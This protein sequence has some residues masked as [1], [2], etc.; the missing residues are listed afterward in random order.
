VAGQAITQS[1][2]AGISSRCALI[3]YRIIQM[4]K[5][6]RQKMTKEK[7]VLRPISDKQRSCLDCDYGTTLFG[8]GKNAYCRKT[9]KKISELVGCKLWIKEK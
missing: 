2:K 7:I 4:K 6:R 1:T 8:G 9:E 3:V 5:N